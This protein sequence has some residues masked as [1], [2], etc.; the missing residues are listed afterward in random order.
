MLS[1]FVKSAIAVLAGPSKF[2]LASV[3]LSDL[4]VD[5]EESERCVGC[6]A[7]GCTRLP[8]SGTPCLPFSFVLA[9]CDGGVGLVLCTPCFWEYIG[10]WK[11]THEGGYAA[12]REG[13]DTGELGGVFPLPP[14]I[15]HP[16]PCSVSSTTSLEFHVSDVALLSVTSSAETWPTHV[17]P[18]PS[19][20]VTHSVVPPTTRSTTT[21]TTTSSTMTSGT[22][23]AEEGTAGGTSIRSRPNKRVV[24][25]HAVLEARKRER[26]SEWEATR[27][28]TDSE[29]RAAAEQDVVDSFGGLGWREDLVDDSFCSGTP[30]CAKGLRKALD[31]GQ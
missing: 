10:E 23:T 17:L 11:G 6:A 2:N 3:P 14:V 21:T 25:L 30:F 31:D 4:T 26:D 16:T 7:S 18:K 8:S 15:L 29:E 12:K 5:D 28:I 13:G 19:S 22:S 1:E 20:W 24:A 27:A 9:V